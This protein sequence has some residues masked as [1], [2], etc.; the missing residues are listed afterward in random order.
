MP[1]LVIMLCPIFVKSRI[2]ISL[3]AVDLY[4][5][6]SSTLALAVHT[7][8]AGRPLVAFGVVFRVLYDSECMICRLRYINR[9]TGTVRNMVWRRQLIDIGN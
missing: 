2:N 8:V 9:Q 5:G 4:V 7:Y 6:T 3:E 1:I